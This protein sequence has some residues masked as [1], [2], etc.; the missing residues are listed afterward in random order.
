[1]Q[2][3]SRCALWNVHL[4]RVPLT[5]GHVLIS[6][7][8][9]KHHRSPAERL[10]AF[11][12]YQKPQLPD[13]NDQSQYDD[14]EKLKMW[15]QIRS[16]ELQPPYFEFTAQERAYLGLENIDQVA[17]LPEE[18]PSKPQTAFP[19]EQPFNEI[20]ADGKN[21]GN[22]TDAQNL[23]KEQPERW[24][25]VER[26]LPRPL[27]KRQTR[28]QLSA[29]TSSGFISPPPTAPELPYFVARTRN[30]LLPVY[31]IVEYRDQLAK[32]VVRKVTGD[33]WALEEE[34]R[35]VIQ[36]L[37]EERI[38]SSVNEGNGE[39]KFLGSF[40]KQLSDRLIELGF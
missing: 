33:L 22:F 1:M 11:L 5:S 35:S 6:S 29:K 24:F 3:L 28:D 37:Q 25:W 19:D 36:L 38:L 31:K 7:C 9:S 13:I 2:S 18:K 16:C 26:L 15:K 32:T 14:E 4:A 17:Y 12:R 8:R 40:E 23:L 34:L 10:P 20:Y 21:E 27:A 30:N 39:I